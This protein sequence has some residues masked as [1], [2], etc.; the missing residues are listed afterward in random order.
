LPKIK[1]VLAAATLTMFA[2]SAL[3]QATWQPGKPP[4]VEDKFTKHD[5]DG[6]GPLSVAE[7]IS[8]VA[9]VTQTDFGKY[10]ADKS[11]SLSK[12]EF[13]KWVAAKTSPPASAPG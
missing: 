4:A 12:E 1:F 6:D 11:K 8:A 10:D 9:K 3:S 13:A 5:T 7:V 2:A